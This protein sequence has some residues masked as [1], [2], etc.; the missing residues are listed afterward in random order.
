MHNF[1]NT[2]NVFFSGE[3][4][5]K[6][7]I[8]GNRLSLMLYKTAYPTAKLFSRFSIKP[9]TVTWMSLFFTLL[10]VLSLYLT[11]SP[12]YFVFFWVISMHLDFSD[13]T[14]ARM[15]KKV[16]K[17][18]LRIDHMTDLVKLFIV[19]LSIGILYNSF[20]TWI[21][22][23]SAV[24]CLMYS[25][26]LT[27]EIKFYLKRQADRN[28]QFSETIISESSLVKSLVGN[29]PFWV[30][31]LRNIHSIFFSISG[32]TLVFFC[33]LPFGETYANGFLFY[34]TTVCIYGVIRA[35]ITL[36]SLKR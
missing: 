27:H 3:Y 14:L 1:Y 6:T 32:H 25:E 30:S 31:L 29:N 13:G 11:N 20:I 19:F 17:S 10:A 9:N 15:T 8:I 33:I 26:I 23:N 16:S 24:F 12:I 7:A 18:A 28:E 34:F 36:S 35:L 2:I 21:L 5:N 22:V 4:A